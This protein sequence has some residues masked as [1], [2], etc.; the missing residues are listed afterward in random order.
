MKS[1]EVHRCVR[2]GRGLRA[3]GG[4]TVTG[5]QAIAV[6]QELVTVGFRPRSRS[7]KVRSV[8]CVT[9]AVSLGFG[10]APDGQFNENIWDM[11]RDLLK[12]DPSIAAAAQYHL[13][14]PGA[15]LRPMPGSANDRTL[16]QPVLKVPALTEAS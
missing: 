7:K 8:F 10:P 4:I 5:D 16:A 11:L 14:N 3:P 12:R 6:Y 2:C 1:P 9:C 15:Q 13:E